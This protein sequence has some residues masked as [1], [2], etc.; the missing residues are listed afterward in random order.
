M[1][2]NI[3]M[4][5][6]ENIHFHSIYLAFVPD[7]ELKMA[8]LLNIRLGNTDVFK[9]NRGKKKVKTICFIFVAEYVLYQQHL[10]CD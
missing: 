10:V 1:T 8:S 4:M 7:E 9:V 2:G 6:M 5:V 3:E